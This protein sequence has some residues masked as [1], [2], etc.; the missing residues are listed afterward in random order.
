MASSIDA[1][2]K[3]QELYKKYVGEQYRKEDKEESLEYKIFKKYKKSGG[4]VFYERIVKKFGSMLKLEIS[5][6]EKDELNNAIAILDLDV[7]AEQ[8]TTSSVVLLLF[9]LFLVAVFAFEQVSAA[10][11]T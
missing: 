6:K 5:Q 4:M 7:T 11:R 10:W 3:V 8:V 9:V 2:K 1:E